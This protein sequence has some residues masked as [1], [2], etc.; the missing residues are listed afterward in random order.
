MVFTVNLLERKNHDLLRREIDLLREA[1]RVDYVH[2]NPVKH[3]LVSRVADWPFSS[4][5]RYVEK[6]DY[7]ENWDGDLKW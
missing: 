4:F 1:L 3:G 6:D 5:H 7:L 2:V